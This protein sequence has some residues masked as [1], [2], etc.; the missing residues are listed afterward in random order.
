MKTCKACD[1]PVP[2]YLRP[3]DGGASGD[4][5]RSQTAQDYHF[6]KC[7]NGDIPLKKRICAPPKKGIS[8]RKSWI[9][10]QQIYGMSY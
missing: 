4:K 7:K 8:H 3:E 9:S 1:S 10:H 2:I 5:A 6:W